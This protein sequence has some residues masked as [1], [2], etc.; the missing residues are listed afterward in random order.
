MAVTTIP[1]AG[2]TDSAVTIAKASGFGK[3]GQMVTTTFTGTESTTVNLSSNDSYT[4]SSVAATLTPTATSSK[5]LV[6]STINAGSSD[7]SNGCH[8]GRFLM[9]VSGGSTTAEF[10]GDAAG[11]R[12]RNSTGRMNEGTGGT[13]MHTYGF[14]FVVTPNTTSAVTISY[15]FASRGGGSG[16]A[17]I[18]RV[19]ND[20]DSTEHGRAASA[21]TL[22]EILA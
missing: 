20:S 17:Y 1:T 13:T 10:R 8:I 6:M 12:K 9:A 2:I 4:T 18:N 19:H 11:S 15:Q 14:N 21:I 22:M 16:T 3:I 5:I 7:A